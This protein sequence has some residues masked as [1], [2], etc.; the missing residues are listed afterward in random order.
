MKKNAFLFYP[1][2]L[3]VLLSLACSLSRPTAVP[4]VTVEAETAATVSPQTQPPGGEATSPVVVTSESPILETPE[5][6]AA[7]TIALPGLKV[8]YVKEGNLWLWAEG[9]TRQLTISGDVYLPRISPGGGVIAFLRPRDDFHIELWA[10]NADGSDERR[11]VSVADLD[12]IGGGVRDPNAVAVNPL[13]FDW[14]PGTR[15]LAFNTH[16]VFQGPGLSPLDDLNLV[17][18]D[19]GEITH[20]LLSGWGGEFFYS[21]D[22]GQIAISTPSSIIL[23]NADASD[24][25]QVFTY[26]SVITYSEYRFYAQPAW[27][28]DGSF[29]RVAI[30]PVDPLEQPAQPTSL[31]T[32]PSDGSTP[33]RDGGVL[34]VSILESPVTYSPDLARL[35]FLVEVG[36]PAEN[37]REL[38]LATYDG[39]GEWTYQK[40]LQLRFG[41]WALDSSHFTFKSGGDGEMWF[42]NVGAPPMPF[43]PDPYGITDVRWVDGT[44]YL[45]VGQEAGLF[46]L[47]LASLEGGLTLLDSVPAPPPSFD[48]AR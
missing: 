15:T 30:P 6:T 29:L 3:A 36:L 39:Q 13:R 23:A 4:T 8:A 35:V 46:D 26:E 34:G 9:E 25:R 47:H 38:R 43:A 20:L 1:L 11:L 48:F 21:P 31:W 45:Y 27:S 17:D 42:G 14:V 5:T 10:V 44:H 19:T 16:Q 37:M 22:G 28:P 41:G 2:L 18:A 40:A 32:I 12:T 24:Y 7:P 33:V